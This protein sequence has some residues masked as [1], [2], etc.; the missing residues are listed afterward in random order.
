MFP[1]PQSFRL[2]LADLRDEK[3]RARLAAVWTDPLTLDPSRRS[4]KVTR[5]LAQRLAELAKLLEKAGHEASVVAKFLMRCLFTMFAEDVELIPRGSFKD[6]LESM[7]E[8]PENFQPMMEALWQTM[9]AGGFSPIL[10]KKLLKFNGG[11]FAESQALPLDKPMLALLIEAA[12][13][14]WADVEPAI[15]GTLLERALDVHERHK[16]GAH[17]T[18]RAYVERL[19]MPTVIE[20]LRDE[21][22]TVY[23]AAISHAKAG[24]MAEA[25]GEVRQ[26]H[27]QLCA[28]RVLDPACGSGNFLYVTLEHMK[29]LEG[30]IL[31][32]L[33]ELGDKQQILESHEVD[34]HQFLGIEVNPRAAAIAD[35]VLWI[36]YLQWHFRTRGKTQPAEPIIRN[37]KNIECR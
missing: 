33:R 4:A 34:P 22:K 25:Q 9:N 8:E 15:F 1:D 26:F 32:A 21:W 16:L 7:R 14:D 13:S 3:I 5:E 31:N 10:R 18:P 30:E 35:L 17:Y 23:A 12:R 24:E 27:E 20:P 37:Y 36:G 29:R 2:K 19:V 28:T 11:L 6:L